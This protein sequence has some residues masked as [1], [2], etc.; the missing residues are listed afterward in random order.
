MPGKHLPEL[1][2]ASTAGW[3][4][5]ALPVRGGYYAIVTKSPDAT[6]EFEKML[7]DCIVWTT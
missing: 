1:Q 4:A 5:L 7:R 3:S 2:T 6:S